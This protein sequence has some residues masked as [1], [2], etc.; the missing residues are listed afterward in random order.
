MNKFEALGGSA[1]W[2]AVALLMAAAALEPVDVGG[3][4]GAVHL[5]AAACSDACQAQPA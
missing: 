2:M 1:V 5:S 3:R 4:Q